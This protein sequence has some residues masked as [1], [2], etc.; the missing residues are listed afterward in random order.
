MNRISTCI[1][2]EKGT[3]LSVAQLRSITKKP[4]TFQSSL[5]NVC[6]LVLVT[7]PDLD[8]STH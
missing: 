2:I 1:A 7:N 3:T 8:T 6:S 5:Y 4:E